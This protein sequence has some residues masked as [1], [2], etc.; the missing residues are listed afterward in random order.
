MSERTISDYADKGALPG[1]YNTGEDGVSSMREVLAK[2]FFALEDLKPTQ[3]EIDDLPSVD[4]VKQLFLRKGEAPK[5]R[6]SL[7]LAFFAQ[8]LTDAVFQSDG[9]LGTNAPH[10]IILNQ[11]YGN[12]AEDEKILREKDG[13]KRG[14]LKTQRYEGGKFPKGEF[15]PQLCTNES[16]SWEIKSD[17]AE[18]SYLKEIISVKNEA[19]EDVKMTKGEHLISLYKCKGTCK[20][21]CKGKCKGKG[22]GKE[23]YLC[24]VGLRQGNL[25]LGNFAITTLLIREHNRLCRELAKALGASATDDEIFKKAQL[26]NIVTYM[27]I[28]IVDYINTIAGL[29]VFEFPRD[30]FYEEKRWC[31]E[32]PIPYHFNIL[33]R[34][35]SM[36]PNQLN[37][38]PRQGI[39]A[40]FANNDLVMDEGLGAIFEAAS[41]QPASKIALANTHKKLLHIE[42]ATID[43]ARQ[44]LQPFNKYKE[45]Y[46]EDPVGFDDFAPDDEDLEGL[47]VDP[48]NIEYYVGVIGE[49]KEKSGVI[50]WLARNFLGKKDP[51]IGP[52]LLDAITR[53][54]FRHILS[55][56]FM[57][58]EFLNEDV[59]TSFGWKNL[60]NT[61][62]VADL[63]KR[64]LPEMGAAADNLVVSLDAPKHR[65]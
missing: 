59:M 52:A 27:K 64:N 7:L 32:T 22:E 61:S 35:H 2:K 11:I 40:F 43:K 1:L 12:T 9:A 17:F 56:R 14:F 49:K 65:D 29:D 54:A 42:K 60:S 55:H 62:S 6:V 51:I 33:Y 4:K 48:D 44:V 13:K 31:R 26:I 20:V 37:I 24:A 34:W 45:L 21:R 57:S 46:E 10:E 25:T 5:S 53:H 50:A 39:G 15:P 16:G 30:F 36:I 19:G 8:H 3:K 38:V 23:K 63:V 41:A 47:Y 58:R 28:V 18:L